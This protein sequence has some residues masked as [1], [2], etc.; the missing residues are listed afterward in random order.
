MSPAFTVHGTRNGSLVDATWTDGRLTGDPPT[1]DLLYTQA[2]LV[3]VVHADAV[4]ARAFPDLAALPADP[5]ADAA[6]AYRLIAH[7]FDT[8]RDT[9]GDVPADVPERPNV[10][11]AG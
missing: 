8:I 4:A 2:E 1:V 11:S 9:T 6:S 5:L 3:Q 7:V 10:D